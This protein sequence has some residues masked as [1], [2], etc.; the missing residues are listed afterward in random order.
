MGNSA[1]YTTSGSLNLENDELFR[2][3]MDNIKKEFTKM[4]SLKKLLADSSSNKTAAEVIVNMYMEADKNWN[5][6]IN[7]LGDLI[8]GNATDKPFTLFVNFNTHSVNIEFDNITDE[9][10]DNVFIHLEHDGWIS[11]IG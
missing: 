4:N 8:I 7:Q 11:V 3:L 9:E 2:E 1:T 10:R 6:Y 5:D